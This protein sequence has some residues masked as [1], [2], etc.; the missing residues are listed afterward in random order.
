MWN[1]SKCS[2]NVL[3]DYSRLPLLRY[4]AEKRTNQVKVT[5][6]YVVAC[7]LSTPLGLQ[8]ALM[9]FYH[10]NTVKAALYIY[11]TANMRGPDLVLVTNLASEVKIIC[12]GGFSYRPGGA[13][14]PPPHLVVSWRPPRVQTRPSVWVARMNFSSFL[15]TN[16]QC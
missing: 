6:I 7:A 8:T 3:V 5:I 1:R 10:S 16:R 9:V 4:S 11:R 14:R 2:R 12:S 13:D 15:N